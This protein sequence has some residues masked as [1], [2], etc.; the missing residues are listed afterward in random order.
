LKIILFQVDGSNPRPPLLHYIIMYHRTLN[1][2]LEDTFGAFLILCEMSSIMNSHDDL[3]DA[4][5]E[6][7]KL[8]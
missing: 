7:P 2:A 1:V 8:V 3:R 6:V 5:L 4:S